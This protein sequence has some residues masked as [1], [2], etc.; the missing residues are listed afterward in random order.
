MRVPL[1]Q[2]IGIVLA[3]ALAVIWSAT[4][5]PSPQQAAINDCLA[6]PEC[7]EMRAN[8]IKQRI[9]HPVAPA[10]PKS[11]S[12][13]DTVQKLLDCPD[14]TTADLANRLCEAGATT[15]CNYTARQN[16]WDRRE[17]ENR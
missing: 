3:L 6:K 4:L 1:P 13:S 9:E 14:C 7:A 17:R 2:T 11:T 15:A 5:A 16:D 10:Y 12:H 8:S